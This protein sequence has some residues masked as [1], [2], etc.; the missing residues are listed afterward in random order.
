MYNRMLEIMGQDQINSPQDLSCPFWYNVIV[1]FLRD[2]ACST[3]HINGKARS[4]QIVT[5]LLRNFNNKG[6]FL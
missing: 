5:L 1:T 2:F 6:A 4:S 3:R